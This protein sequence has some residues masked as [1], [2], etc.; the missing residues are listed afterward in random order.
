MTT[1]LHSSFR[2]VTIC[3]LLAVTLGLYV[4]WMVFRE[5]PRLPKVQKTVPGEVVKSWAR[6]F[7]HAPMLAASLT[8]EHFRDGRSHDVWV[9]DVRGFWSQ[10]R[11]QYRNGQVQSGWTKGNTAFIIFKTTSSSIWG[12]HDRREEYKLIRTPE[13]QWLINDLRLVHE[14][15]M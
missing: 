9:S 5:T 3:V 14:K 10:L 15:I 2:Q 1:S 13:G 8:T 11:F 4:S 12:E 7:P 6:T